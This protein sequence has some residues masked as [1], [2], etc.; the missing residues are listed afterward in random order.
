MRSRAWWIAGA[1]IGSAIA[2]VVL[3]R[4]E[5]ASVAPAESSN[6]AQPRGAAEDIG[7]VADVAPQ[8]IAV[9]ALPGDALQPARAPLPGETAAMATSESGMPL[10][11]VADDRWLSANPVAEEWAAELADPE[12]AVRAQTDL[13]SRLAER[14]GLALIALQVECKTTMCRVEMTQPSSVPKDPPA[15]LLNT[16]GMQP[17]VI[18]AHPAQPGMRGSVAFLMRPGLALPAMPQHAASAP[19]ARAESRSI[20]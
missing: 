4:P 18:L 1:V 11:G 17:R 13:L 15:R 12:W 2:L 7:R 8:E 10:L 6:T 14:P 5:F 3:V 20:E 9:Q 19:P 16:L